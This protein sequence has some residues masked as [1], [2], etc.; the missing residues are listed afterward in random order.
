MIFAIA[1]TTRSISN[2][3]PHF[4]NEMDE[5]PIQGIE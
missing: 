2:V 1:A 5:F 3:H 4:N